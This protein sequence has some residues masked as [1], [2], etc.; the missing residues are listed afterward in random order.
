LTVFGCQAPIV[1]PPGSRISAKLP[2]S[3]TS[4]GAIST[5]PP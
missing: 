1:A 5:V 4:I 2:F 3:P